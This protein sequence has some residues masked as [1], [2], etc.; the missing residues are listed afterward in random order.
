MVKETVIPIGP[1][2]PLLEEPEFFKFYVDGERVVDADL[3]VGYNHRGIEKLGEEK[4]YD[5]VPFLVERIC[6]I[7]STSHPL[8][9]VLAF[10]DMLGIKVPERAGYIRVIVAELERIH[11]HLLWLGLAGHFIGYNTVFMWAWKARE[12]VLEI[13]EV[14]TGNR[15]HY[16]MMKPGG[17]RRDFKAEDL[18]TFSKILDEVEK[19]NNMIT[20]AILDDPVIAARTKGVGVLTYEDA[21][22]MCVLGP[23]ARASGVAIDVRKDHP[24]AVYSQLKF[25]KIVM[26]EGDVFAKTVVRLLEIAESIKILRQCINKMPKGPIDVEIRDIPDGE[27]GIGVAEAPRGEV[28]HYFRS[29]GT[30]FPERIKI[31]APSFMNVPSFKKTVIG[32][33]VADAVLITAAVDPCYCCTERMGIVRPDTGEVILDGPAMVRMSQEKTEELRRKY[34]A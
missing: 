32:E 29:N 18:E 7:C 17:V 3:R 10:E 24:Y 21:V 26:K 20:K 34:R 5:Q 1:F 33:A 31:R 9:N 2:H 25:E 19:F 11:S 27:E 6:G 28:F 16:G 15:N 14:L 22:N 4:T 8:A 12:P 23:V 13:A 30:G